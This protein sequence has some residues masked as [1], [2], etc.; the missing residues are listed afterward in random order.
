[1]AILVTGG[2]G[3]IGSQVV[4]KLVEKGAEVYAFARSPEKA[5]FPRGVTPVKGDLMDLDAVQAA[6]ARASTLFLLNAVTPDEITQALLTFSLA[7]EAG[8]RGVVYFSV[9]N[10]DLFTDV[11]HFT[12]KYAVERMIEDCDLPATILRP[13]YF[14]QNDLAMKDA[15][16]GHG[17][18]PWPIGGKG[19]SMVDTR[20]IAE[21]VALCL[22][23][24]ENAPEPLARET[25]EI[26]GPDALTGDAIAE[27]WSRAL[28]REVRYGGDDLASFEQQFATFAPRW[29]ARDMRLMLERFQKH[30]MAAKP[31][32]IKRLSRLLGHAPRSYRDFAA[33]TAQAWRP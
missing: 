21:V 7:R 32:T 29:M 12:G 20:D 9:F 3:A 22:L 1:M 6:L 2:T 23:N 10:S 26:A 17:V 8:I 13:N 19:V 14:M 15:L 28:G 30:G 24:R 4:T 25:I 11:P 33:E 5:Q 18:Y 27:I 31:E 16:L